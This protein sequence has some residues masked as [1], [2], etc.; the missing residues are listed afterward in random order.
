MEEEFQWW[1]F[2]TKYHYEQFQASKLECGRSWRFEL[3]SAELA[4]GK[5]PPSV[6]NENFDKITVKDMLQNPQYYLFSVGKK[7]N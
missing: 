6:T 5:T 7:L 4:V 3:S 2:D 1:D